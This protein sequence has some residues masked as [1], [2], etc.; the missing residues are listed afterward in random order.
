RMFNPGW[1]SARD[2][3]FMVEIC[4]AIIRSGLERK[5]F[6]GSHWRTDCPE[7]DPEQAKYNVVSTISGDAVKVERRAAP[8]LPDYLAAAIAEKKEIGMIQVD[9]GDAG[10]AKVPTPAHQ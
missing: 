1:H 8:P 6:R 7:L 4:E 2:Q 9:T 3:R 5:E 10:G